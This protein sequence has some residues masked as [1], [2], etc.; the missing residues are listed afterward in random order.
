MTSRCKDCNRPYA[1]PEHFMVGKLGPVPMVFI[2][3]VCFGEG[4]PGC[5]ETILDAEERTRQATPR[6]C[7]R[8]NRKAAGMGHVYSKS[9][10][11]P[12]EARSICWFRGDSECNAEM[13][14]G[15]L[16]GISWGQL[17]GL[18]DRNKMRMELGRDSMGQWVASARGPE[19]S[20]LGAG[21]DIGTAIRLMV[22]EVQRLDESAK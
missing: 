21:H 11:D 7:D 4:S 8:C 10:M 1:R 18:L 20:V 6:K 5:L 16:R 13:V 19:L 17:E 12:S 15:E 22:G 2:R 3:S 14:L 9:K